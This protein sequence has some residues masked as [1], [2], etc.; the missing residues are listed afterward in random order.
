MVQSA[1]VACMIMHLANEFRGQANCPGTELSKTSKTD[2]NHECCT[3]CWVRS[4]SAILECTSVEVPQL[5]EG[6]VDVSLL[7]TARL[8]P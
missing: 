7:T 3:V 6:A 2:I 4:S 8:M 1:T 5:G